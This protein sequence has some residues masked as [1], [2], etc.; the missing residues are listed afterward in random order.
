MAVVRPKLNL[1]G[2]KF[3]RLTVVA[4]AP[5][6]NSGMQL[7]RCDCGKMVKTSTGS[8]RS[9]STVSCGCRRREHWDSFGRTHGQSRTHTWWSWQSMISRC[10]IRR[11]A[12]WRS[13]G[14]RGIRVCKRWCGKNGFQN[15]LA[16]MG[17]RPIGHTLDRKKVNG[18]YTSKNCRWATDLEQANNTTRTVRITMDGET[19]SLSEWCKRTGIERQT[20]TARLAV[21]WDVRRALTQPV[22]HRKSGRKR[23]A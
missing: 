12:S 2:R 21:G 1:V 3:G 5:A 8:L 7:C 17:K 14:G 22:D 13:Y 4:R 6:Q 20:L 10:T 15:F 19:L 18:N 16:D 11:T 9:G 23:A